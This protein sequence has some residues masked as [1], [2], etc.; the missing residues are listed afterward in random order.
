MY[1][2]GLSFLFYFLTFSSEVL[3]YLYF[4][5]LPFSPIVFTFSYSTSFSR[6]HFLSISFHSVFIFYLS[7]HHLIRIHKYSNSFM[8]VFFYL[9]LFIFFF[10]GVFVNIFKL[11]LF[12]SLF[13][14]HL[15]NFYSYFL[16]L[17]LLSPLPLYLLTHFFHRSQYFLL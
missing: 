12:F 9:N 14:S 1:G 8:F 15:V 13:Q 16:R 17:L 11:I 4:I 3:M 10:S 2:F 6:L 7:L 5:H